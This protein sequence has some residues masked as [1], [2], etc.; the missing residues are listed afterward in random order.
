MTD[1]LTNA[2]DELPTEP[3]STGFA[4]RVRARV[5]RECGELPQQKSGKLLH[6]RFPQVAAAMVAA[7]LLLTV[8]FWVG[9]G[10]QPIHRSISDGALGE[11]AVLTLDELFQNRAAL[12]SWDLVLDGKAEMGFADATA[13]TYVLEQDGGLGQ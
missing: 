9:S 12:E 3:A 5:E 6:G 13:G 2:L 10:A 8:G 11:S 4:E 1:W 7:S